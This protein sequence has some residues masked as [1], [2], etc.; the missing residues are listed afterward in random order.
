MK[1]YRLLI[2]L[3]LASVAILLMAGVVS[4]AP[5]ASAG[6]ASAPVYEVLGPE[7][8]LTDTLPTTHPVAIVIAAYFNLPYTQ[9]MALHDDGFGF[10]TIARAYLTALHSNGVLTPEQVLALRLDG[11]GWG[12]IKKDYGVAPGQNGLGV[13]MRKS[14]VA[15]VVAPEPPQNQTEKQDKNKD[16]AGNSCGAPGKNKP[17]KA[18]KPEITRGPKNK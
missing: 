3:G 10:G 14:P 8:P 2:T 4:A 11:T 13:I 1:L 9:V 15:P 16:C 5:A 6:V 17:E 12:Q 7:P 18:P